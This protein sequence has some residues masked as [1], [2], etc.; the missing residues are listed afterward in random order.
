MLAK[1]GKKSYFELAQVCSEKLLLFRLMCSLVV[2][3]IFV[4]C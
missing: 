2:F 1:F 3:N 4:C